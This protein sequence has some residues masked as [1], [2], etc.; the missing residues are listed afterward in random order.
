MTL[1]FHNLAFRRENLK[2]A[3]KTEAKNV[4]RHLPFRNPKRV[5]LT[6]AEVYGS[7]DICLGLEGYVYHVP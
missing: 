7:G 2:L 4:L 6:K 3:L 1:G 5:E